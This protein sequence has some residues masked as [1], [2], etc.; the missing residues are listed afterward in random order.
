V[1]A[2]TAP[3][4]VFRV[5]ARSP[6]RVRQNDP[7]GALDLRDGFVAVARNPGFL[8]FKRSRTVGPMFDTTA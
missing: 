8:E 4:V 3:P 1:P 6:A 5:A 2:G 7:L